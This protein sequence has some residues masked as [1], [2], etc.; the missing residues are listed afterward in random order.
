MKAKT[1]WGWGVLIVWVC[2]LLLG[3]G[4]S[5]SDLDQGSSRLGGGLQAG[6]GFNN[7]N[8]DGSALGDDGGGPRGPVGPGTGTPGVFNPGSQE[9]SLV[10][11][12]VT[13]D[14]V[15][16]DVGESEQLVITGTL[17]DT[18]TVT[19][20]AGPDVSLDFQSDSADVVVDSEGLVTGVSA[21]SA[22]VTVHVDAGG[23]TF[24]DTV[25]VNV[26]TVSTVLQNGDFSTGDLSF[27]TTTTV[28]PGSF[29]GFPHFEVQTTQSFLPSQEGNPFFSLDVPGGAEGF[30]EQTFTLPDAGSIILSYRVW[31]ALDPVSA[32]VSANTLTDSFTPPP[33]EAGVGIPSGNTD[34]TRTMDISS[35][36][37][38]SVT[39]RVGA[40]ST[41]VNGTILDVDDIQLL[42]TP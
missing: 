6:A 32:F 8:G 27:W 7:A 38:Q 34:E 15:V 12:E 1:R 33:L 22:I 10:S 28:N 26:G 13:P 4:S 14:L 3:C 18:D 9:G 29:S 20:E 42:V 30:I 16:L 40:T 41:G 37:G 31:G 39:L 21:G 25:A 2:F 5:G 11:I 19:V 23:Q 24:T 17:D 36:A 35:L